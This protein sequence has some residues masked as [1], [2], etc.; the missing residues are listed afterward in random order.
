M[1][2]QTVSLSLL[3]VT[4]AMLG[5]AALLKQLP[6]QQNVFSTAEFNQQELQL[7]YYDLL[8]R[9]REIYDTQFLSRG[10]VAI[11]TLTSP[12]D[13][14][15]MVKINLQQHQSLTEGTTFRYQPIYHS[16]RQQARMIKS[17]PGYSERN[18]VHLKTLNYKNRR[19]IVTPSGQILSYH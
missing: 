19:L 15:Y 11:M 5:G 9:Q 17:I 16:N 18:S 1:K 2:W 4:Q 3:L 13:S 6:G 7:G 14:Q 8:S 10:D 12:N